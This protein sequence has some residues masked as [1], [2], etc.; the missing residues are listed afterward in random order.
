MNNK[1]GEES[2]NYIKKCHEKRTVVSKRVRML[3]TPMNDTQKEQILRLLL[4]M[5]D[6]I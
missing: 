4:E 2:I 1:S 6:P 5:N 3:N